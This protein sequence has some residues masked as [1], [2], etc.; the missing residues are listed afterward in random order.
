MCMTADRLNIAKLHFGVLITNVFL[1]PR[2]NSK[3]SQTTMLIDKLI[4]I[5]AILTICLTVGA[6][7]CALFSNKYHLLK[8]FL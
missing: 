7:V 5:T 4:S 3:T 1:K 2:G 8:H 6:V